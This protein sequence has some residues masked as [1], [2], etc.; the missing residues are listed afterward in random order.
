MS[1]L[2]R[3]KLCCSVTFHLVAVTCVVWLLYVLINRTTEEIQLG[4]LQWPFWTTL[5][6]V[7]IGFTG[8]LVFMY[9]QCKVYIQICKKWKAYN[10]TIV[11]QVRII[12]QIWFRTRLTVVNNCRTYRQKLSRSR[13]KQ[14]LKHGNLG[15]KT[16]SYPRPVLIP[17]HLQVI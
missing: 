12:T 2:E 1:S 8:G 11:V 10:R 7:A 5:V 4:E 3:Q 13:R 17:S 16:P 9:I 6:V 15:R 14:S